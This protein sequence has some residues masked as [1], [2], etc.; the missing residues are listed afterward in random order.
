[1]I[2]GGGPPVPA[3]LS[4]SPVFPVTLRRYRGDPRVAPATSW[5]VPPDRH[6]RRVRRAGCRSGVVVRRRAAGRPRHRSRARANSLLLVTIDTLRAD[7]TGGSL[8]PSLNALAAR[9]ARFL[10]ARSPVPLTLPAHASLMTGL[11]P[12]ASRRADER[13]AP[14][15]PRHADAGDRAARAGY[16]TAAFIGAYVLDPRFG[17]A[18]GF[19]TYDAEIARRDDI[20]GELE[21]ERRG[22]VVAD[23]AIAWLR[24]QPGEAPLFLWVHLY[25]PH[26]PVRPPPPWLDR[27]RRRPA[28]TTARS[29]TPTPSSAAC[30]R[31]SRRATPPAG[32]SSSWPATT[33]RAWATTASRRTACS[34]TRRRSRSRSS[35]PGPACRARFAATPRASWM[36]CPRVMGLLGM[37]ALPRHRM[38]ATSLQPGA[39]SVEAE[40]YLET[41]Y[42]GTAG[43]A[44]LR[45]LV[46]GRW[47]YIGGPE[48]SRALRPVVG[49]ARSRLTWSA[50]HRATIEAMG[51]RRARHR[52]RRRR[53]RPPRRPRRKRPSDCGRWA[54]W[55]RARPGRS[56]ARPPAVAARAGRGLAAIP[57]RARRHGRRAPRPSACRRSRGSRATSPTRRSSSSSYG[58]ALDEAGRSREAVVAYRPRARAVAGEHRRCSRGTRQ[59]RAR[60]GCSKR[61]MKAEQAVLALDPTDAAAENGIGL[62]HADQGRPGPA[63]DAFRRA[64]AL[65]PHVVSYWVNLGNACRAGRRG[66]RS[67]RGLPPR[68]GARRG[69]GGCDERD[70]GA[71]GAGGTRRPRRSRG[72]RARSRRRPTST[73]PG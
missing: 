10:N 18:E 69:I 67:R 15:R 61:R 62:L 53:A 13:R 48:P 43:F 21:A 68:A 47:K 7:R 42:P 17:L 59:P 40:I 3:L 55:P 28:R 44:S 58:R 64:I 34:S 27:A 26:A 71:A 37:A 36:S 33:A 8:T 73:R 57:G 56:P 70:R 49:P 30:S 35:S 14:P 72:S 25:D 11:L 45:G 6:R 19:D 31:R 38:A 22:D 50:A 65:D 46:A 23:R 63:R 9:G 29:P 54:T 1:M 41:D 66:A 60:R 24:A 12:P 20:A 52:L 4:R 5:A 2:R 16:R 51:A 32:R 39:A